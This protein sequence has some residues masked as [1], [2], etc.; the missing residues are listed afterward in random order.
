MSSGSATNSSNSSIYQLFREDC[1]LLLT[2]HCKQESFA[3]N[4]TPPLL[5]TVHWAADKKKES[6]DKAVL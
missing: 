1:I 2:V 6:I 3:I 5:S 4:R